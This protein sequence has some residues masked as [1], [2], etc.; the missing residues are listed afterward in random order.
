MAPHATATHTLD[1]LADETPICDV[2]MADGTDV[3]RA[4]DAAYA[5]FDSWAE[6]PVSERI[7]L[8]ERLLAL[9]SAAYEGLA[10]LM[11]REMGTVRSFSWAAQSWVGQQHLEAAIRAMRDFDWEESRGGMRLIRGPV[12]VCA[13]I[14]PWNWPMNRL[15]VKVAPALAAGCTMVAKPS[16]FL[17]LSAVRFAELIH[18]V[19]FPP[20]VYNHILGSGP[21]AGAALSKHPDVAMVSITGSTRA[22]IAVARDA[23]ETIKRVHQEL[24]GKSVNIVLPD[25][26]LG[27]AVTQGIDNCFSNCGQACKAP[28]RLLVPHERMDEAAGN[29]KAYVE[30][31]RVGDPM[32]SATD[33]GPVVN[34]LQ[35]DRIQGVDPGRHRRGCDARHRRPGPARRSEPRLVRQADDLLPHRS[36]EPYRH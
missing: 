25:A 16:E 35:Y 21:E 26:D 30:N 1:N 19:G 7:A 22:G 15:V 34:A 28:A 3:D 20:G 31:M 12:G 8:M 27:T 17:P 6:T 9:Y 36:R 32:D 24:G 5:A 33:Q 29:S 10:D 13:L 14:T 23:A 2:P 18:E 4:I 11:T